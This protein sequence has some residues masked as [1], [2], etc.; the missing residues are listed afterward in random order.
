VAQRNEEI[1]GVLSSA[2]HKQLSS[3]LD[4]LIAQAR[5]GSSEGLEATG[6]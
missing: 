6:E 1:F 5:L 4:R 2:E 3:I